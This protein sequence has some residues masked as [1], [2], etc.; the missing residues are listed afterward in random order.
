[1]FATLD[2]LRAPGRSIRSAAHAMQ[3]ITKTLWEI[4]LAR[5][6]Q[7]TRCHC[8]AALT[9]PTALASEGFPDRTGALA[10]SV[11]RAVSNLYLVL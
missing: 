4:K 3:V 9:R 1:M 6:A 11:L 10:Y 8:R 2:T 5:N 7:E